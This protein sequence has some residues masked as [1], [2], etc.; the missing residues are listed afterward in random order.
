MSVQALKHNSVPECLVMRSLRE[1]LCSETSNRSR[2]LPKENAQTALFFVITQKGS[3]S[4]QCSIM[5][6]SACLP[7]K[8][9]SSMTGSHQKQKQKKRG[10]LK[11]DCIPFP[12]FLFLFRQRSVSLSFSCSTVSPRI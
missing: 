5:K 1:G 7:G 10:K 8:L 2:H 3:Q 4:E 12:V 6:K 11:K 9:L